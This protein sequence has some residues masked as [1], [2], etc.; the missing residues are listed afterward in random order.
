MAFPMGLI[1]KIV[2]LVISRDPASFDST[3]SKNWRP[4]S[5]GVFILLIIV[6]VFTGYELSDS[7]LTVIGAVMVVYVGGRSYEKK[8]TEKAIDTLKKMAKEK[9]EGG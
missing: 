2:G 9:R 1:T 6:S 8:A 5:M 3:L 7:L 4:V